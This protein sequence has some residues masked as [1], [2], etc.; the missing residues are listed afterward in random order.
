MK[1][2]VAGPMSG[3]P[4][5]NFPAFHAATA[6]LRS[7]GLEVVSPA[8]EDHKH[9]IGVQAERSLSGDPADIKETW[10][11]VL[12][13]DVRMLAD[14]GIDGIVFLDNWQRSRGAK[15]EATVGILCG[16][17]FFEYNN[18]ATTP[19]DKEWVKHQLHVS[20]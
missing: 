6:F 7:Q 5:F 20:L 8:E 9:G 17:S 12:A 1:V 19:R 16:M 13:R 15:L 11:Q 10:G 14:D 18:G 4:A 3:Y 2:Y